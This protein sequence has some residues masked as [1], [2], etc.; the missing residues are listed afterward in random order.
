MERERAAASGGR[1][2]MRVL[3]CVMTY[4]LIASAVAGPLALGQSPNGHA[5]FLNG[6]HVALP[7]VTLG[8]SSFTI[9]AWFMLRRVATDLD[10]S[11]VEFGDGHNTKSLA[12]TVSRTAGN[13]VLTFEVRNSGASRGSVTT[14]SAMPLRLWAHVAVVHDAVAGTTAIFIDGLQ[15]AASETVPTPV[16]AQR[17]VHRVGAPLASWARN[18][19]DGL[20]DDVRVWSSAR[21]AAD[22]AAAAFTPPLSGTS[23]PAALLLSFDFE[24]L[25]APASRRS[26]P[27]TSELSGQEARRA[28]IVGCSDAGA[29]IFPMQDGKS[30]CGDGKRTRGVEQCDDGGTQSGDGCSAN[31]TIEAGWVCLAGA[32]GGTD[33][34]EEGAM[35]E[36]LSLDATLSSDAAGLTA[37]G[38]SVA[39]GASAELARLA[40]QGGG[41]A[42]LCSGSIGLAPGASFEGA[43][44]LRLWRAPVVEANPIETPANVAA[45]GASATRAAANSAGPFRDG[46]PAWLPNDGLAL[47]WRADRSEGQTLGGKLRAV[48]LPSLAPGRSG[49]PECTLVAH[50]NLGPVL[51]TNTPARDRYAGYASLSFSEE[52]EGMR[53]STGPN[54]TNGDGA[55]GR[56]SLMEPYTVMTVVRF[57]TRNSMRILSSQDNNWLLGVVDSV[58]GWHVDGGP[59]WIH[60]NDGRPYHHYHHPQPEDA[61][62]VT[63]EAAT[64]NG[65]RVKRVHRDG[66]LIG[67]MTYN[68]GSH[69]YRLALGNGMRHKNP[70][71]GDVAEV[72]AFNRTLSDEER[73]R[74]ENYIA[75]RYRH[76]SKTGLLLAASQWSTDAAS[77]VSQA[78]RL[79]AGVDMRR[80]GPD[81]AALAG[82]AAAGEAN[83]VL[84]RFAARVQ[85][86]AE[87]FGA[88]LIVA[89]FEDFNG[90]A[91]SEEANLPPRIE[92]CGPTLTDA[93]AGPLV[94]SAPAYVP[95]ALA[96]A[97]LT[98][99]GGRRFYTVCFNAGSA[100]G[101]IHCD[102]TREPPTGQW[103]QVSVDIGASFHAKYG[104]NAS[105]SSADGVAG[106]WAGD[107]G[108]PRRLRLLVAAVSADDHPVEA[109][110]DEARVVRLD[111]RPHC[112]VA[113]ATSWPLEHPAAVA[114]R[115]RPSARFSLDDGTPGASSLSRDSRSGVHLS[116]ASVAP[117]SAAFLSASAVPGVLPGL[118]HPA[119]RDGAVRLGDVTRDFIR[120]PA[121]SSRAS[122]AIGFAIALWVQAGSL[123]A[124]GTVGASDPMA[125][126]V[127]WSDALASPAT[128]SEDA[129][130]GRVSAD[131]DWGTRCVLLSN[132]SVA[133]SVATDDGVT[134]LVT[135]ARIPTDR[136]V[137]IVG[138]F[139]AR[140]GELSLAIDGI[141]LAADGTEPSGLWVTGERRSATSPSVSTRNTGKLRGQGRD[142]FVGWDGVGAGAAAMGGGGM[143]VDELV[144]WNRPLEQPEMARLAR[145]FSA[146]VEP[147]TASTPRGEA[148]FGDIDLFD[149]LPP[150]SP[151]TGLALWALNETTGEVAASGAWEF[152]SPDSSVAVAAIAG[153]AGFLNSSAVA[154]G[155]LVVGATRGSAV[156]AWQPQG[157]V[158]FEDDF[159]DQ[160]DSG[161]LRSR[162][163]WR[164]GGM[165]YE[166][167]ANSAFADNYPHTWQG[168]KDMCHDR[169]LRLCDF[170]SYCRPTN[171]RLNTSTTI[172]GQVNGEGWTPFDNGDGSTNTWVAVGKA[173]A[174]RVCQTYTQVF[175]TE[176]TFSNANPTSGGAVL[177]CQRS[178]PQERWREV[179]QYPT[180]EAKSGRTLFEVY[181]D[182]HFRWNAGRIY[183]NSYYMG[184]IRGGS[185]PSLNSY[186]WNDNPTAVPHAK[187]AGARCKTLVWG[188][189]VHLNIPEA[190]TWTDYTVVARVYAHV[191]DVGVLVRY[192][193][194]NNYYGYLTNPDPDANCAGIIRRRGPHFYDDW[195]TLDD[196]WQQPERIVVERYK[197]HEFR[198]AVNGT[199]GATV[200]AWVD[201][202]LVLS[203]TDSQPNF[204]PSGS[205]AFWSAYNR[206]QFDDIRIYKG[207]PERVDTAPADSALSL[208][209]APPLPRVPDGGDFYAQARHGAGALAF[210]GRKARAVDAESS[211]FAGAVHPLGPMPIAPDSTLPTEAIVRAVH[212][213][214]RRLLPVTPPLSWPGTPGG[215]ENAFPA[216]VAA[217][218]RAVMAGDGVASARS[219]LACR[220]QR[221]R[222]PENSPAGTTLS[223]PLRAHPGSV[224]GMG[225]TLGG[226]RVAAGNAVTKRVV[227]EDDLSVS[228]VKTADTFSVSPAD[229][230]VSVKR[231]GANLDAE[232]QNVVRMSVAA[233]P[234]RHDSG[235]LPLHSMQRDGEEGSYRELSLA[236]RFATM[237]PALVR[238]DVIFR[239]A[240]G[241]N[242]GFCFRS[243]GSSSWDDD[244]TTWNYYG[245]A[246]SAYATGGAVP[247]GDAALDQ[248]WVQDLQQ[249]KTAD[250]RPGGAVTAGVTLPASAAANASAVTPPRVRLWAPTHGRFARGAMVNLGGGQGAMFDADR[251]F[252]GE[253][254]T[255]RSHRTEARVFATEEQPP[256]FDSGWIMVESMRG[257]GTDRHV[258]HG[259]NGFPDRT[260]VLVR[261]V[262]GPNAGFVFEAKGDGLSRDYYLN[263]YGGVVAAV[264]ATSVELYPA[265]SRSGMN[266]AFSIKVPKRGYG[267]GAA[268]QHSF[269]AEV[270]VLAWRMGLQPP[271]AFVSDW[272]DTEFVQ[273]G[274]G[275]AEVT[276]PASLVEDGPP[277][278]V[279]VWVRS[280]QGEEMLVPSV[281]MSENYAH[282]YWYATGGIVAAFSNSS[283]RMWAGGPDIG[284]DEFPR[285]E[286]RPMG[287]SYG[288]YYTGGGVVYSTIAT[289]QVRAWA[290]DSSGQADI[291]EVQVDVVDVQEPP[292]V[293]DTF[294]FVAESVGGSTPNGHSVGVVSAS[295]DDM[296]SQLSFQ[297][298]SG[299]PGG[300][301]FALSSSTGELTVA[302]QSLLDFEAFPTGIDMLVRVSDGTF[303][304]VSRVHVEVTNVNDPVDVF[305]ANMSV[306]ENL[307]LN[308]LVGNPIEATDPDVDQT[309]LFSV[310]PEFNPMGAVSINKCSGQLRVANPA[311]FNYEL[312]SDH[313]IVVR[314]LAVDDGFP[315][316]NDTAEVILNLIDVNDRPRLNG[317]ELLA[318]ENALAGELVG[319]IPAFDEDNDTLTFVIS[320][321]D[322]AGMFEIAVDGLD[323]IGHPRHVL[324]MSQR[325]VAWGEG[326]GRLDAAQSAS[327]APGGA[328]SV[329][330][331]AAAPGSQPGLV[332]DFE[333][334]L[335]PSRQ[336]KLQIVVY[337]DAEGTLDTRSDVFFYTVSVGDRND[338]PLAPATQTRAVSENVASGTPVGIRLTA[339]DQ[340]ALDLGVAGGRADGLVWSWH[341]DFDASSLPFALS[342]SGAITVSLL[343]PASGEASIDFERR[344]V[345]TA[346][347]VV[348]DSG[349]A[350]ATLLDESADLGAARTALAGKRARVPTGALSQQVNI[351]IAVG[352]VNEPPVVGDGVLRI[353]EASPPGTVVGW[354]NVSDPDAADA[355]L[356]Q[357]TID[358]DTNPLE[359]FAVIT[360][361]N[362]TLL[363]VARDVIDFESRPSY[364][365][366]VT[367]VDGAGV[368]A[369][370]IVQ[371]LVNDRNDPPTFNSCP[372]SANSPVE[373]RTFLGVSAVQAIV[374]SPGGA[375]EVNTF[376][377]SRVTAFGDDAEACETA[378]TNNPV[379][380]AW[381]LFGSAY[382]QLDWRGQCVGRSGFASVLAAVE[383][384]AAS[385]QTGAPASRPASAFQ[386]RTGVKVRACFRVEVDE[387]VGLPSSLPELLGWPVNVSDF[388]GYP[389]VL[390]IT[391]DTQNDVSGPQASA[392]LFELVEL[393][394]A[395]FPG[396][397]I[398]ARSFGLHIRDPAGLDFEASARHLV[399]VR[400]T[401]DPGASSGELVATSTAVL[402]IIVRDVNERPVFPFA[403]GASG[404]PATNRSVVER[405]PAGTQLGSPVVCTDQ[406]ADTS[407]TYWL[408][409]N[410]G[411]FFAI[412]PSSGQLSL[413]S[414]MT[415]TFP[416]VFELRVSCSDGSLNASAV[417]T[418]PVINTNARPTLEGAS[419]QRSLQENAPAGSLVTASAALSVSDPDMGDAH[420]WSIVS[421]SPASATG[422]VV[423]DERTGAL[424]V[425]PAAPRDVFNF[426]CSRDYPEP[427]CPASHRTLRLGV[428][429]TDSG[430]GN[431]TDRADVVIAV[432]NQQEGVALPLPGSRG[433]TPGLATVELLLEVR[434]NSAPG[435]A[436]LWAPMLSDPL[437]LGGA[438]PE[439]DFYDDDKT[440]IG[441]AWQGVGSPLLPRASVAGGLGGDAV[442]PAAV[443]VV[444]SANRSAAAAG[445]AVGPGDGS[446][447]DPLA[448]LDSEQLR[449]FLNR[450]PSGQ[451]PAFSLAASVPESLL[452]PLPDSR[453]M[454][455]DH[456]AT[457][458]LRLTL[459]VDD[460]GGLPAVTVPVLL[461]VL[462]QPERP[463]FFASVPEGVAGP[464]GLSPGDGGAGPA[465]VRGPG[466]LSA[467][468]PEG[469][470][471]DMLVADLGQVAFDPDGDALWFSLVSVLQLRAS[472]D[473]VPELPD[474]LT[475]QLAATFAVDASNGT[476]VLRPPAFGLNSVVD[477]ESFVGYNVTV[478]IADRQLATDPDLQYVEALVQVSVTDVNDITITSVK[479]PRGPMLTPGGEPV[480]I[481]GTNLGFAHAMPA[482]LQPQLHVQYG[483]EPRQR[484]GDPSSPASGPWVPATVGPDPFDSACR[485]T[486]RSCSITTPGSEITCLS[487]EG[488]G[489]RHRW[490]VT[491]TWAAGGGQ[492][493]SRH[494][495]PSAESEDF[496]QST[497]YAPPVVRAVALAD[498][499]GL[500]TVG[501]GLVRI[502]GRNL[503]P[504]GSAAAGSMSA[505][506]AP[507]P[508]AAAVGAVARTITVAPLPFEGSTSAAT[509]M[510]GCRVLSHTE[511]ECRAG[512]GVGTGYFW[513][514]SVEGQASETRAQYEA[515]LQG[516]A[517]DDR[518]PVSAM[519]VDYRP[520]TVGSL[521][522]AASQQS[523]GGFAANLSSLT[524]RGG[525]RLLEITGEDFG[526][527]PPMA[528]AGVSPIPSSG[529]VDPLLA[530]LATMVGDRFE[531]TVT[532][533]VAPQLE[534]AGGPGRHTKLLCDVPPGVGRSFRWCVVI[535]GQLSNAS[536]EMT[537]YRAPDVSRVFGTGAIASPTSGGSTILIEGDNL[538]PLT[539]PRGFAGDEL[540]PVDWAAYG[541]PQLHAGGR[542]PPP[543]E[544]AVP[545]E[546]P[547]AGWIRASGCTVITA[548]TLVKCVTGEGAGASLALQLS[549]G[550]Q[551]SE[552]RPSAVSYG[553]PF[554]TLTSGEASPA[555]RTSGGQTVVL[556]GANMGR[557]ATTLDVVSYG[558]TGAEFEAIGCVVQEPHRSLM[559]T[560]PEGAG[561][562]LRFRVVVAGV[563]SAAPRTQ[564]APPQLDGVRLLNATAPVQ[565]ALEGLH[566]RGGQRF[567]L[568][569]TNLGAAWVASGFSYID[570]V[571]YGTYEL[572]AAMCNGSLPEHD[573]LECVTLPGVGLGHGVQ[574][575]VG[576]QDSGPTGVSLSFQAPELLAAVLLPPASSA[577]P[578]PDGYGQLAASSPRTHSTVPTSGGAIRIVGTNL[579]RA[580]DGLRVWAGTEPATKAASPITFAELPCD[581]GGDS[582]GSVEV[583][584]EW[585]PAFEAAFPRPSQP[586]LLVPGAASFPVTA[587]A[588]GLYCA[589]VLLPAGD[590]R[591][592]ELWAEVG[593]QSSQ[594]LTYS[595][596][597][598]FV[599][600]L[601]VIEDPEDSVRR[602][603][604]LKGGDF[605]LPATGKV[606]V[607]ACVASNATRFKELAARPDG[608]SALIEDWEME[609]A[610]RASMAAEE[611]EPGVVRVNCGG[612]GASSLPVVTMVEC[613]VDGAG[614]GAGA[615]LWSHALVRCRIPRVRQM[616]DASGGAEAGPLRQGVVV[617]VAGVDR[618]PTRAHVYTE[619]SP[620]VTQHSPTQSPSAGGGEMSVEGEFL[621]GWPNRAAVGVDI[622]NDSLAFL[623]D[624]ASPAA[625]AACPVVPGTYRELRDDG[626][627]CDVATSEAGLCVPRTRQRARLRCIVPP[628][629]GSSATAAMRLRRFEQTSEEAAFAYAPPSAVRLL[630]RPAT[631]A[632]GWATAGGPR[633]HL[634]GSDFGVTP[635]VQ[636]T[637]FLTGGWV[638]VPAA[639]VSLD[640]AAGHTK[641]SFRL[642]EGSGRARAVR[643]VAGDQASDALVMSYDPPRLEPSCTVPRTLSGDTRGGLVVTLCGLNF[644]PHSLSLLAP[645]NGTAA[646]PANTSAARS[647]VQ[648]AG[649]IVPALS[650][651]HTHVSFAMPPGQ[652]VSLSIVVTVDGQRSDEA[653]QGS[654]GPGSGGGSSVPDVPS[655]RFTYEQPELHFVAPLEGPTSAVDATS[656]ERQVLELQGRNFGT[657]PVLR[658][659]GAELP[660]IEASHTRVRAYVP[661]G[662]GSSSVELVAG[663]QTFASIPRFVYDRPQA[664]LL[665][666]ALAGRTDACGRLED[667]RLWRSRLGVLPASGDGRRL[668]CAPQT[669]R[670]VGQSFGVRAPTVVM[671]APSSLPLAAAAAAGLTEES[672]SKTV[673]RTCA[674]V[675]RDVD[676]SWAGRAFLNATGCVPYEPCIQSHSH[677]QV[678]LRAPPGQGTGMSVTVL[679]D[680]LEDGAVVEGRTRLNATLPP[681]GFGF[682]PPVIQQVESSPLDGLGAIVTMRGLNL[683]FDD[684]LFRTF[685]YGD[686]DAPLPYAGLQAQAAAERARREAEGAAA[687]SGA[688]G[689]G[690]RAATAATSAPLA[691]PS[692]Q[693]SL[694]VDAGGDAGSGSGGPAATGPQ[695]TDA[696]RSVLSVRVSG[697]ECDALDWVR[698]TQ[699]GDP[700]GA[701]PYLRCRLNS[702][703]VGRHN[704]SVTVAG[705]TRV[706]LAEVETL[707]VS[708]CFEGA[709]GATG[710]TCLPCPTGATCPGTPVEPVA[711]P[712]FWR[713]EM[714]PSDPFFKQL[715]PPARQDRP[716]C[717]LLVSCV[718]AS[719]CLRNNTCALGYEGE[720]CSQCLRGRYYR[721]DGECIECP[722]NPELILAAFVV[723]VILV[724]IGAYE[725]N[726]RQLNLGWIAIGLDYF[727]VLSLFTNVKVSWPPALKELFRILS[728]FNLNLDLTA[729][730]CWAEGITFTMR[731]YATIGMPVVAAALIGLVWISKVLWTR[732]VKC[733]KLETMGDASDSLASALTTIYYVSYLLLA[734]A[735]VDVLSCAPSH[736]PDPRG[737]VFMESTAI[738]CFEAGG[739]HLAMFPFAVLALVV[740]NVV[741]PAVILRFLHSQRELVKE[742]QYLRAMDTGDTPSTNPNALRIRKRWM[743]L[744]YL[745]KPSYWWFIQVIFA[746]KLGLAFAALAFRSAP[747]LQLA[748]ALIVTFYSFVL[749]VRLRPYLCW[750]E[751]KSVLSEH[752]RMAAL[753]SP[754]HSKI[755]MTLRSVRATLRGNAMR[756]RGNDLWRSAGGRKAREGK[757]GKAAAGGGAAGA[758]AASGVGAEQALRV[759]RRQSLHSNLNTMDSVLMACASLV[760]LGGLLYE[761]GEFSERDASAETLA[762]TTLIA[763][764]MITG[765]LYFL[766]AAAVELLAEVR[767]GTC[768]KP[769]IRSRASAVR[770][771]KLAK[772]AGQAAVADK[773]AALSVDEAAGSSSGALDGS[774]SG[775]ATGSAGRGAQRFGCLARSLGRLPCAAA[776]PV[777]DPFLAGP[778]RS[779]RRS[780]PVGSPG[781]PARG[782]PAFTFGGGG[783][784]RPS[785]TDPAKPLVSSTSEGG[786]AMANPM[787]A[788]AAS[789][790]AEAAAGMGLSGVGVNPVMARA[791]EEQRREEAER[792]AERTKD[793]NLVAAKL[794]SEPPA[795]DELE[796]WLEKFEKLKAQA[797]DLGQRIRDATKEG[798][799][800]GEIAALVAAGRH[801]D[802]SGGSSGH[803]EAAA[804][805]RAAIARKKL[806]RD[807]S[808][809]GSSVSMPTGAN[810]LFA[811]AGAKAALGRRRA[812]SGPRSR[813]RGAAANPLLRAASARRAA[814][815]AAAT[816]KPTD[817]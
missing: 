121:F 546:S 339:S 664:T 59:S 285:T 686:V 227:N 413:A 635:V 761:A 125:G 188:A 687:S 126:A 380:E 496:P 211:P 28:E 47:W 680:E 716:T 248:R 809:A 430:V 541:R 563:E 343:P 130:S 475:G 322:S 623:S 388:E 689:S 315:Q 510:S 392:A 437:S 607:G 429:V 233:G 19:M 280:R 427:Q 235:W 325:V 733:Q 127:I 21:S 296:D 708:Q 467:S 685:A 647:Y 200:R 398:G 395:I 307:A 779:P 502:Q 203:V 782:R 473:V 313:R 336:F 543:P 403:L 133:F 780:P 785:P 732:L 374:P 522:P 169:G 65:N 661:P 201:G 175:G 138:S 612:G 222:V 404:L 82:S 122:E 396:A 217:N 60:W 254:H 482:G 759:L 720:R 638:A 794:P 534:E 495:N 352:D 190:Y 581:K 245:G 423:I 754:L 286:M 507:G 699:A 347:A 602:V 619:S 316:T 216:P 409:V 297:L 258:R 640:D 208:V 327:R 489:R 671:S 345:Y 85:A 171:W 463:V 407:L 232:A 195:D 80:D 741:I 42:V 731:W 771:G 129:G 381:T 570:R 420:T 523:G 344:S 172:Y 22:L 677:S 263:D 740:Y 309:I 373:Y 801:R 283:V 710:E 24:E 186:Y 132:G 158:L 625:W 305:E 757:A 697:Q 652:G 562:D 762:V 701:A 457:P 279:E 320:S 670:I 9:E 326:S 483:C 599:R 244:D 75:S 128:D 453:G 298:L 194:D 739:E 324:R 371:V 613:V 466:Q 452:S 695:R 566:T 334:A 451:T 755:N 229:G 449:V 123:P 314:I 39:D 354:L 179:V 106:G 748:V 576:M 397:P 484:E 362:G 377:F 46:A 221:L 48:K 527:A 673:S 790:G 472:G 436:L 723:G 332:L 679:V 119:D 270:R 385:P 38:W 100:G 713:E 162:Y 667:V 353:D 199:T 287:T 598:P 608:G 120:V 337:D 704:L 185:N 446:S 702:A 574:V 520:P 764:V 649:A 415:A 124:G 583:P 114:A 237:D 558:P 575:S 90:T 288:W 84:L 387:N 787:A 750:G 585:L 474:P 793:S 408:D 189:Y 370:G 478:R 788:A 226:F 236:P 269:A 247:R 214:L 323:A 68:G 249:A 617:A 317:T 601:V 140:Y 443:L 554:V 29:C 4:S 812:G 441:F 586:S 378:C 363:T 243:K 592:R 494:S 501:G 277:S 742:D 666:A 460:A 634:E 595:F 810:P 15:R 1:A 2:P 58:I 439:A 330:G 536:T 193:D 471:G 539:L 714:P 529:G 774:D 416:H 166:Y 521:S 361:A 231:G 488:A 778:A 137:H 772:K 419:A 682:N 55:G 591:G 548:H 178:R 78:S 369:T 692:R 504:A 464:G 542:L 73:W 180:D 518:A 582:G 499:G 382:P 27:Q 205:V 102:E 139:A 299:N 278:R 454:V 356:L 94:A 438:A 173:Y 365:L 368:N 572:P 77:M 735:T 238:V 304:G 636:M 676:A 64:V 266:S 776:I 23:R 775:A 690:D 621:S 746:R 736:P 440:P 115:M 30:V 210:V 552:V 737:R 163:W 293:S 497:S 513:V 540:L 505:R 433:T 376:W 729:P 568:H 7:A 620:V 33:V 136:P 240:D 751:A 517:P 526:P 605:G 519:L 41:T 108:V 588:R 726:R 161:S 665:L 555:A 747:S 786:F 547:L 703:P 769:K 45:P 524:T 275:F 767:P 273:G 727:Q 8:G 500:R 49:A 215:L 146:G 660:L 461:R 174:E 579:G 239:A 228:L 95:N 604:V 749:T 766:G 631:A 12:L 532:C 514:L 789:P 52:A 197:W 781:H 412:D 468:V 151:A 589:D 807:V 469:S 792:R 528:P 553:P 600:D 783:A 10:T 763:V 366:R 564:Y 795:R 537:H 480:V 104:T 342:P 535:G 800:G 719:A 503:G 319:V 642:P 756:N 744:Y 359:A 159:S 225:A 259:L 155:A 628:G 234:R 476:L 220:T 83:Q 791:M 154:P 645:T 25:W 573:R 577:T 531:V 306:P 26:G 91:A 204:I 71:N 414:D 492:P 156:A 110:L 498:P 462:D 53:I 580:L 328:A 135:Q 67:V 653:P 101:R 219:L 646:V 282:V 394:P 455:L 773:P 506:I 637:S 87:R 187:N 663:N 230:T 590:G 815:A 530:P 170:W 650:W 684:A 303:E 658:F 487:D 265:T 167:M 177:C 117:P 400:A 456:E 267:H 651:N 434:E 627:E 584:A 183:S 192:Q 246:L 515:A 797:D 808:S 37:S 743:R 644:G 131:P 458:E 550:G 700:K 147:G 465:A 435:S 533:A 341:P 417:V 6:T 223:V 72:I 318:P 760:T 81:Y 242:E 88:P 705:V 152:D 683:G 268:T 20:V 311:A 331:L 281:G 86:P 410:E 709:Y 289:V 346:R 811:A 715:C 92:Q 389:F 141:T 301:L 422:L 103:R 784:M 56:C 294:M 335:R 284:R 425:G 261:A 50:D 367:A 355:G 391:T 312:Y 752:E 633:V 250:V 57:K 69:P 450:Y 34:C 426:E 707:V 508:M 386:V 694:Q 206:P 655:L 615:T 565:A 62:V 143:L 442:D 448:G 93:L 348:T 509:G 109:W 383:T 310:M 698:D 814:A 31:C 516:L 118:T 302:N 14:G 406:D 799:V 3:A 292:T 611:S 262:S 603:V 329:A 485:F 393:G 606:L 182:G 17:R 556:H 66:A 525:S 150:G 18:D 32:P 111:A 593:G 578:A 43:Q 618:R 291:G 549:V 70:G 486:A 669:L 656:G 597:D 191:R 610:A 691:A 616:D 148:R 13:N 432:T 624:P 560:T 718:P 372:S 97:P 675:E 165:P 614:T 402:A 276:L 252:L 688:S 196:V 567:E 35:L 657:D 212:P 470:P 153:I 805:A 168:A 224:A 511:A 648:V 157:E 816:R 693:R 253:S 63:G 181:T 349:G 813:G 512:A 184:N 765:A 745:F 622:R 364:S 796:L 300:S 202:K 350:A 459:Q 728:V 321:G 76:A 674:E 477:F 112:A 711:L 218:G 678:L 260:R 557:D 401:D 107:G 696:A 113:R 241:V 89:L 491:V 213:T 338:A 626:E 116:A 16:S 753:G 351:T 99:A 290:A 40:A 256:D 609:E 659:G 654:S 340:D 596:A 712:G 481:Q 717:P 379:C 777:E 96:T 399:T 418:L 271:P 144:L 36:H 545:G 251:N 738:P 803:Q 706:H 357:V 817:A 164:R 798:A 44:G 804:L 538:G 445:S 207:V 74:V 479:S 594:R 51:A 405:D 724:C 142:L 768:L 632:G 390:N 641:L 209:G 643:V 424:R 490:R 639:D 411:G 98:C 721:V 444:V 257:A 770:G 375:D 428:L 308:A 149:E 734:R 160:P 662:Q 145:P 561:K 272:L 274:N 431:L 61:Y 176:A 730:E 421:T 630:G 587:F 358:S 559:C 806:A 571:A 11:L 551:R 5:A 255:Q 802:S 681:P 360:S 105:T 384:G 79:L 668:C 569:G 672:L 493:M 198:V 722:Q 134:T 629:V 544:A 725:M 54:G 333:D 264:T 447:S 758:P 295:D